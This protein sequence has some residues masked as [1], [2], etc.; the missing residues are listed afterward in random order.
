MAVV[1]VNLQEIMSEWLHPSEVFV[2]LLDR[3]LFP[4]TPFFLVMAATKSEE[5]DF[6]RGGASILTPLE[7]RQ[8]SIKAAN[9]LFKSVSDRYAH[10]TF[11]ANLLTHAPFYY[12]A[13]NVKRLLTSLQQRNDVKPTKRRQ[14]L[15]AKRTASQRLKSMHLS[16]VFHSR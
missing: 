15:P 8:I 1:A 9:D 4:S 12:R 3:S 13:R 7:H 2:T 14:Q 11:S 5:I 16:I 10:L 6:P